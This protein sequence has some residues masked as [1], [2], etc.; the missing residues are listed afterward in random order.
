[1]VTQKKMY[2]RT[3]PVSTQNKFITAAIQADG[4]HEPQQLWPQAAGTS[5]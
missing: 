5:G 2:T 3:V 1:M 4:C